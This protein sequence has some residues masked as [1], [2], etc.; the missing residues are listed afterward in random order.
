MFEL[1]RQGGLIAWIIMGCGL[2]ALI[3]FL[4]RLLSL[5]RARIKSEDFIA[6]ICNNLRRGNVN[7]ALAI[8]DDTP[9]PVAVIVRAAILNRQADKESIR[10][11]IE[12]AG[13][14][15]ISRMERRLS[16]L[17]TVAQVAPIFGLLGTVLGLI[18]SLQAMKLAAPLVQPVDVMSGLMQ[19]LVTTAVGLAVAAPC[20]IAF[21]FLVGKVEK[22][23]IDMERSASDLI[24]FMAGTPIVR[25]EPVPEK[26][27]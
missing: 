2:A 25:D 7:E 27:E 5:H 24:A 8:C 18:K 9:G 6:G 12:N 11:A 13:R 19:A 23:V 26:D 21:S 22:I 14:T 10:T 20:Y 1:L 15:E 4:E 17:A 3:L 16:L